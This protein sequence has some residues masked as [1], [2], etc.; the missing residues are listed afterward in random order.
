MAVKPQE[1]G[2]P[3]SKRAVPL[4]DIINEEALEAEREAM[5][6]D[7]TFDPDR[8]LGMHG[9][10][11]FSRTM[12]DKDQLVID[13]LLAS[14]PKNQGYYLKLY[15]EIFPGRWELKERID[16]FETWTDFEL[17]IAERV[18]AMTRKL[19][20]KKWGSALYRVVIWRQG[21]IREAQKYPVTDVNVDAG[22][23]VNPEAPTGR[24]DPVEAANEQVNAL[25]NMLKAVET[26]MPRAVDPN[27]QFQAI[28]QAFT[29]GKGEQQNGQNQTQVMMMTMMTT[30]MTGMME[31]MKSGRNGNG[32]PEPAFEERM[33]KMME[34]MKTFGLGQTPQPKG[35]AEQMAELKLLGF[36][37]FKK[38]DTIDQI[39][40]LKALTG[41]LMDVM[42]NGGQMPERPGIFEKLVDA[43]A[44]HIPKIFSDLRAIT[45][46][47]AMAQKLQTIRQANQPQPTPL[48]ERPTTRYGQPVGPQPNRMGAGDAFEHPPDMDPYSGFTTRPFQHPEEQAAGIEMFGSVE[49]AT[50]E[51][52]RAKANGHV[53]QPH[54]Q[55]ARQPVERMQPPTG[56][57]PELPVFLQQ[58]HGL[59][60][61][62]MVDAYGTLYE[63]L[64]GFPETAGMIQGIQQGSIDGSVLTTELQRTGYP[65]LQHPPFVA[66]AK[67]YLDGFVQWV[68]EHTVKR[69][70]AICTECVSVHVF[71]NAYEYQKSDRLCGA[72][73]GGN[74]V[75]GGQLVLKG[76]PNAPALAEA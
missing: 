19:G 7:A 8:D 15:K 34:M 10:R 58:L 26:I 43:V 6:A 62:N 11:A 28:V 49:S 30:L 32:A 50:P 36:D 55:P 76:S 39:A 27:I 51:E 72:E 54:A 47:A 20:A 42:P 21:G 23:D 57:P 73:R 67:P 29:A 65:Q 74:Q 66:K 38:D 64:N 53:V 17:E 45:D 3:R 41:S 2:K 68:L 56:V 75:C 9:P 44:P 71:D 16:N 60:V 46:N 4:A 33:A 12:Q 22:D 24:I 63:T 37:P 52:L 25:G 14:L 48:E 31:M 69:A 40:K 5:G 1:K 61:E 59:I 13:E 35:L 70:E 18:K